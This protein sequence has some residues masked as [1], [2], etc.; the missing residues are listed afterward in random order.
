M[1][2]ATTGEQRGDPLPWSRTKFA[3]PSCYITLFVALIVDPAW[4]V[5][6]ASTLEHPLGVASA[7]RHGPCQ[8]TASTS[9]C[10]SVPRMGI[11]SWNAP[12]AVCGKGHEHFRFT[13]LMSN[14]GVAVTLLF[15]TDFQAGTQRRRIPN[16][17]HSLRGRD[18]GG[19]SK[20]PHRWYAR[21]SRHDQPLRRSI[22]TFS[23]C[24]G[25]SQGS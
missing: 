11:V 3:L 9:P 13:I 2:G 18:I 15:S 4:A 6:A 14:G 10:Q 24:P 5:A 20:H 23:P 1:T 12:R 22:H 17:R 7:P 21:Q 8:R 16:R 25:A 19:I